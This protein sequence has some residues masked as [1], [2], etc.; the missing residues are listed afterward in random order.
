MDIQSNCLSAPLGVDAA[1][2]V[3]SHAEDG[4]DHAHFG[5][6]SGEKV[7]SEIIHLQ[8]Y[9]KCHEKLAGPG[10]RN[11]HADKI[12]RITAYGL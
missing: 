9:R 5:A 8:G 6:D 10:D 11:R 1:S 4:N 2:A 12:W 7:G 3:R